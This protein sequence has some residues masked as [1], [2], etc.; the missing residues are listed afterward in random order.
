MSAIET[1]VIERWSPRISPL[2]DQLAVLSD[3]QSDAAFAAE[4]GDP[5]LFADLDAFR[6]DLQ[7]GVVTQGEADIRLTDL[8]DRMVRVCQR[9]S[10]GRVACPEPINK[11]MST[12]TKVA[13]GVG[14]LA[15]F[16]GAYYLATR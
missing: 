12:T 6:T 14:V 8:H 7:A 2:F 4:A 9:M 15:L 5:T 10:N 13:I 16:G 11:G 3:E 1:Y